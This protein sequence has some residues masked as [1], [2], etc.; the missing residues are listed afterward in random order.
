MAADTIYTGGERDDRVLQCRRSS[1]MLTG[2]HHPAEVVHDAE[3][4]RR[5]HP[6]ITPGATLMGYDAQLADRNT[7]G[8][9]ILVGRPGDR[10]LRKVQVKAVRTPP[11]YVK[12]ADFRAGH[13]V[14]VTIYVVLGPPAATKPVRYFIAPNAAVASTVHVPPNGNWPANGFMSLT[15]VAEHENAWHIIC[16][17]DRTMKGTEQ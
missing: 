7:Q 11:W 4:D 1:S 6:S 16:D 14:P 2:P 15:S 17:D 12:Q 9:D 10:E 3:S 8:H 13:L 5:M